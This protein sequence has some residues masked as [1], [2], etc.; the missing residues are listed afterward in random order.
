MPSRSRA[1]LYV[2]VGALGAAA[3]STTLAYVATRLSGRPQPLDALGL[4]NVAFSFGWADFSLPLVLLA[5]RVRIDRQ[6]R[7]AVPIHLGALAAASTLHIAMITAAAAGNYVRLHV[8]AESH[9]MR[10]TM[11]AIE[12]RL[13]SETFFRIHRPRIVNTERIKKLHRGSTASTS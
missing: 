3:L 9:R 12:A 11:N 10:E 7:V 4:L 2:L 1:S 6:P 13:D 5:R 8:G